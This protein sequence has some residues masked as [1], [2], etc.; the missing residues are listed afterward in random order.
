MQSSSKAV[1]YCHKGEWF[2]KTAEKG[3]ETGQTWVGMVASANRGDGGDRTRVCH[4]SVLLA[5]RS[6]WHED[7]LGLP[8]LAQAPVFPHSLP[9]SKK[10]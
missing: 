3:K 2:L 6:L 8:G 10:G 9:V 5:G 1:H 7:A 4:C